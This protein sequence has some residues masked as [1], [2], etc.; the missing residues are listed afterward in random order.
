MRDPRKVSGLQDL[1]PAWHPPRWA[2]ESSNLARILQ[3]YG[4][5]S[6]DDFLTWSLQD[7]EDFWQRTL[8]DL[9]VVWRHP[10]QRVLDLS[11]GKPWARWFVGGELNLTESALDAPVSDGHA[12][13]L[14]LVWEGEDGEVRRL[15]YQELLQEVDRWARA[16]EAA[17]VQ[18]GDRV[19]LL[20]PMIPE[21]AIALL[22][23]ARIGAIVVPLFSG[24]GPEAIRVRL[25]ASGARLLLT[26]PGFLRNGRPVPLLET[27]RHA[28]QGLEP[29]VELWVAPFRGEAPRLRPGEVWLPERLPPARRP[30]PRPP[31]FAADH[32]FMLIYTS[33]T[34][35]RPKGTVHVHAGFPLKA[36]QDLYH[37][38]DLRPGDRLY[39]LTDIGW[40]MGP[41]LV[42]GSLLNRAA[43]VLYEGSPTHPHP[44]RLWEL[45]QRHGVTVA[46][47][48][49]T[50]IRAVMPYGEGI[51]NRYPLEHLRILGSTGEPWNPEPWLWTL[52][53]VGKGRAPIINYSG[54]TEISG[55][56]LGCVVLRPLKPASFNTVV[57]GVD[58]DV[59]DEQG[60][61]VVGEPGYLV[62]RNVNPG[63]TRG[64][65]QEPERYL[66][67]YWQ[68]FEGLW[69][70]GD[71]ALRDAEGYFY[72]LGRADDT[73]KVAGKRLGPAEMESVAVEHPAV[74]EAAVI[75]VP[76]PV[77]GEV[78][79]VFV[80]LQPGR[81][82]SEDLAREIQNWIAER[83]GKA[84][85][86][87]A[88]HFLPDLPKTRN[89][90]V[91]R[92]VLRRVFLGEPPG[93]LSAL[94]NPEVLEEVQRLRSA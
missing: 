47:L 35:G 69:D 13:D 30:V 71:L 80:V 78:P 36:A 52:K 16:L 43:M 25:Q 70:H 68:R 10:F 17:G 93:D 45:W 60:R 73:L 48:A 3:R 86:P 8:E 67:T 27:A 1:P 65:W 40:M 11:R 57:P 66:Q 81:E 59:V 34:T 77:K 31:A 12:R 74:Q 92:R 51:P 84:L 15:T 44:G 79:V 22:A 50:L 63:M 90:K 29:A 94:V 9:K 72:I 82:A 7:P 33:G 75:G 24:F 89:A 46:G 53:H 49:P 19:G 64:F 61:P 85:K 28:I 26:V 37:L 14:A 56:I 21:V 42:L 76:H 4:F 38:F 2:E 41:W 62:I 20:M 91:M 5:A 39:W 23:V 58:A 88:V 6:Y 18:P 87:A 55:G 32:P 54:G 83:M